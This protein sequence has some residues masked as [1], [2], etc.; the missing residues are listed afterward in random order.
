M[1]DG[2]RHDGW[3]D[4]RKEGGR[5]GGRALPGEDNAVRK[6]H[7]HARPLAVEIDTTFL[8]DILARKIKSDFTAGNSPQANNPGHTQVD[9]A[10][11]M[12]PKGILLKTKMY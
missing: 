9:A 1:D 11:M 7:A 3:T 8:E 2:W 5:E 6:E 10:K 4:G 12:F